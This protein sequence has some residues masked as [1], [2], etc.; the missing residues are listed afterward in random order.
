MANEE[1]V[2]RLVRKAH[3]HCFIANS[4]NSA[5]SIETSVERR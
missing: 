5:M 2:R 1:R 3:E 4:L